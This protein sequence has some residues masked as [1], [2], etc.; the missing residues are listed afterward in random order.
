MATSEQIE[1]DLK[2]AM[3]ARDTETVQV[4]RSVLAG[5][6][7]LRAEA[8]HGDEVTEDEVTALV[9]KEAKRR[10]EAAESYEEGGRPELAEKE[11]REL[12]VLERYL[13]E[14]LSEDELRAI[15][16]ETIAEVGA[17]EPGDLGGVMKAVIPKVKGRADGKQVNAMVRERLGG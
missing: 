10:A 1:A 3:K 15:V 16:D 2:A 14:R 12:A 4:L 11:R 13:P 7:N 17:S 8:G 6:K 5:I 9:E